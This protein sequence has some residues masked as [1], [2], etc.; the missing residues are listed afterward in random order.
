M[1]A[2]VLNSDDPGRRVGVTS[3]GCEAYSVGLVSDAN[4]QWAQDVEDH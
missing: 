1:N 4:G 2:S 3:T